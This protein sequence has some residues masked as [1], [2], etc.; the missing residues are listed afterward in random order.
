M[1]DTYIK[2]SSMMLVVESARLRQTVLA[3]AAIEER[4]QFS[5]TH[6]YEGPS[7]LGEKL[8]RMEGFETAIADA[9]RRGRLITVLS[10]IAIFLSGIVL[11]LINLFCT[12]YPENGPCPNFQGANNW[13]SYVGVF[14]V[15]IFC[16]TPC[17]ALSEEEMLQVCF[18]LCVCV[19]HADA[20][21]GPVLQSGCGTPQRRADCSQAHV[22]CPSPLLTSRSGQ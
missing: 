16:C 2:R 1:R 3:A 14:F 8:N 7:T 12:I 22:S 9:R 17:F 18:G 15:A 6:V 21:V 13:T 10:G 11:L 20:A 19:F 4:S 5:R